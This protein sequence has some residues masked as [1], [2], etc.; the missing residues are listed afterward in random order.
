MD[1]EGQVRELLLKEYVESGHAARQHEQLTR[2][3]VSVFLPILL[4]LAAFVV[5]SAVSNGTKTVLAVGGFVASL[6]VL[7]IVRRHQLDYQSYIKRARDIEATIKVKD[8]QV[9]K[10]YTLGRD[11]TRGSHTVSNKTA[12]LVLF[13]FSATFFLVSAVVYFIHIICTVRASYH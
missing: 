12:F 3:S 10:L 6:L 9:I 7:N 5:G 8:A 13:V 11:A 4:A 2:A 1:N